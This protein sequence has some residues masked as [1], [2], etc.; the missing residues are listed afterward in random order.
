MGGLEGA[1]MRLAAVCALSAAVELLLPERAKKNG[2]RLLIALA[3]MLAV[4]R[5]ILNH[6]WV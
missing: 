3:A 1:V 4:L 6:E 2:I 5:V